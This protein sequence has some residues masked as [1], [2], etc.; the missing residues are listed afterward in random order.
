MQT[1]TFGMTALHHA[2]VQYD[3]V[4]FH[5][6]LEAATNWAALNPGRT[7]NAEREHSEGNMPL[8]VQLLLVE[9]IFGISVAETVAAK[10]QD[11]CP[12]KVAGADAVRWMA[13]TVMTVLQSVNLT[14]HS[15]GSD[16]AL[17]DFT[18]GS[19]TVEVQTC[20]SAKTGSCELGKFGSP[21]AGSKNSS[22]GPP[23]SGW[24]T[25]L[26]ATTSRTLEQIDAAAVVPEVNASD[27][28][29]AQLIRN[30]VA[31]GRPVVIRNAVKPECQSGMLSRLWAKGSVKNS[32]LA[33]LPVLLS[34][35]PY[36]EDGGYTKNM[37]VGEYIDQYMDGE[38]AGA[39]VDDGF[40]DV[41]CVM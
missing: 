38:G 15:G 24:R 9:N 40:T 22:F 18:N 12:N 3:A 33:S 10:C 17:N 27:T 20:T 25:N 14:H 37:T 1:D 39:F 7:G 5:L 41:P 8:E 21:L 30:F 35:L 23:P 16:I 2:A 6:I 29:L 28:S 36:A 4:G 34:V 11:L 26:D 32:P 13:W 31:V 19:Q